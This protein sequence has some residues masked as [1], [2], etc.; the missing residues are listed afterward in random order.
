MKKT[1]D[2]C[3]FKNPDA[4]PNCVMC[5]A[6]LPPGVGLP[7]NARCCPAPECVEL[8]VPPPARYCL[9]CGTELKPV[10]YDLWEKKF[11]EPAL[12]KDFVAALERSSALLRGAE[13]M[14]LP[15]NE[16]EKHLDRA[17]IRH[18][19]ATRV[20][21]QKWIREHVNPLGKT[22]DN[23]TE[24]QSEALEL[25]EE[26]NIMRLHAELILRAVASEA[27]L[28]AESSTAETPTRPPAQTLPAVAS[29]PD[30]N[31][32]PRPPYAEASGASKNAAAT[33]V[34][35]Y[36][37]RRTVRE[38][39]N[40]TAAG[41][42]SD[43]HTD[44]TALLFTEDETENEVAGNPS[45]ARPS[46]VLRIALVCGVVALGIALFVWLA[47]RRA[48]TNAGVDLSKGDV[49]S[50]VS[51][52][53][54]DT[55]PVEFPPADTTR[56]PEVVASPEET[57]GAELSNSNSGLPAEQVAVL[58]L[59]TNADN[60]RVSI[61]GRQQ[62]LISRGQPGSFRLPPG[63]QNVIATTP[64]Y[65]QYR[66]RLSLEAGEK[67][68]LF[69]PLRSL[70]ALPTPPREIARQHFLTA[71]TL[72]Q[73]RSYQAAIEQVDEGLRVDPGNQDLLRLKQNIV[74]EIAVLERPN[75][76]PVQQRA[77]RTRDYREPMVVRQPTPT[78]VVPDRY[79]AARMIRKFEPLYPKIIRD[80]RI[81]GVVIVDV[82]L[83]E[84][85]RVRE[86][87]VVSGP[88]ML[89]RTAVDAA[90]RSGYSPARRNGQPVISS[91]RVNFVF[92][93]Y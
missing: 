17:F 36:P 34:P 84:L 79:E 26:L 88:K 38:N 20:V 45:N 11:V 85:G 40:P 23:T 3:G 22:R 51:L 16:A 63:V 67:R 56:R 60:V 41:E 55:P 14:G 1:C 47:S 53:E 87:S 39:S 6:P 33:T 59:F 69:V 48:G 32:P 30:K 92:K 31:A 4:A 9:L 24:A 74:R 13:E 58:I 15:A 75:N 25:A 73:R 65:E 29:T 52:P 43:K 50:N 80:M 61:N 71:Q 86:V 68:T 83:D 77:P 21:L 28:S 10:S 89:Q 35:L 82:S 64:G 7:K 44:L 78:P 19:G 66:Q 18:A 81:S 2:G 70:A 46:M 5:N 91:L 12:K 49:V 62:G 90:T 54:A 42:L 8:V 93:L 57:P 27:T 72:F 76:P 37:P